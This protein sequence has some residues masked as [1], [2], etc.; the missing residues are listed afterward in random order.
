M[1]N[2]HVLII[3]GVVLSLLNHAV[4][5]FVC[6][7][8]LGDSNGLDLTSA[9]LGGVHSQKTVFV[10]LEGNFYFG[11]GGDDV[12]MEI[13]RAEFAV[14][15]DKGTLTFEDGN[16]EGILVGEE[17][18]GLL[19]RDNGLTGN[20]LVHKTSSSLNAEGQRSHVDGKG[21]AKRY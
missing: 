8:T 13:K 16:S 20:Y 4:Y 12:E 1:L 19:A 6:G 3:L 14:V 2:E 18:L 10:D 15:F 11:R 17:G 7:A 9:L 21:R 5:F